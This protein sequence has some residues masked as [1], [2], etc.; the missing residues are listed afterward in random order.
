MGCGCGER[1]KAIEKR[2]G[3]P[4]WLQH[5]LVGLGIAATAATTV[6]GLAR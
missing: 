3:V 4:T 5:L 2:F 6:I 1:A